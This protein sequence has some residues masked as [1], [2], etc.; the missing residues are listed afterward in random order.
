MELIDHFGRVRLTMVAFQLAVLLFCLGYGL[1]PPALGSHI[2]LPG[3]VM[4]A[5]YAGLVWMTLT[6]PWDDSFDVEDA[7][8]WFSLRGGWRDSGLIVGITLAIGYLHHGMFETAKEHI[9]GFQPVSPLRAEDVIAHVRSA[10]EAEAWAADTW[11][12]LLLSGPYVITGVFLPL[13]LLGIL[14]LFLPR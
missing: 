10:K 12:G 5:I 6:R 14:W 9:R 2:V 7:A 11:G 3:L 4:I 1:W 13:M 8:D